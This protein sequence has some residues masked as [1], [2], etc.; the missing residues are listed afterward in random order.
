MKTIRQREQARKWRAIKR[1]MELTLPFILGLIW[2]GF[3]VVNFFL[4]I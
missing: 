2:F 3:I 4:S 1:D